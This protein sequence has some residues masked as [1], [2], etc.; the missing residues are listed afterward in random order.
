MFATLGVGV[1][2]V[3]AI[4]ASRQVA[5]PLWAD[6]LGLAPALASIIYGVAA[7]VDMAVFYPAGRVMDLHGRIWV[8]VPCTALIGLSL[9]AIP[10]TTGFTSLLIVAMVLGFGNGIGSGIVMTLG[11]DSA[12]HDD[13]PR[14][15]GIWRMLVDLGSSG[16]PLLLSTLAALV[17]LAAGISTIGALGLVAA[18]VFW[19]VLPRGKPEA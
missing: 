8:A 18:V 4:R 17:S 16:G 9:I 12:P 14:F 1:M 2:L 10:F 13:R 19:R 6:A 7:L 5:V 15:L 11:A 3:G